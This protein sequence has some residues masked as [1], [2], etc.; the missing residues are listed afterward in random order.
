M[1]LLIIPFFTTELKKKKLI[2]YNN[3]S[4]LDLDSNAYFSF[5]KFAQKLKRNKK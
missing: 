4:C 2:K 3:D 1:I 5:K